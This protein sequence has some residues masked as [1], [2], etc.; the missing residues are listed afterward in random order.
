MTELEKVIIERL[1]DDSAAAILDNEPAILELVKTA[2]EAA[3]TQKRRLKDGWN[4]KEVDSPAT[5]AARKIAE[6]AAHR[7][8]EELTSELMAD[9]QFRTLVMQHLIA[10][11]PQAIT[12][13]W[14]TLLDAAAHDTKMAIEHAIREK[15]GLS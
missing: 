12:A 14:N 7:V 10:V 8:V 6:V 9:S 13:R 11:M 2:I 5:E 1:R 15:A 3:I 4:T